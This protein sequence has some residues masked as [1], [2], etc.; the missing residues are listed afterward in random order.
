MKGLSKWE[1]EILRRMY[2]PVLVQGIWKIRSYPALR[3][4]YADLDIVA[5]I[6]TKRQARVRRVVRMHQ[7]STVKK[8]SRSNPEESKQRKTWKE[9]G[10]RCEGGSTGDE[11]Q[12]KTEEGMDR[13]EWASVF[14]P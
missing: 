5:D 4:L 9:M 6:K 11:C 3:E 13:D 8:I 2:G 7:G 10:G 12:V 14:N 1:R